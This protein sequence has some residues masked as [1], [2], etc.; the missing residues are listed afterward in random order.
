[1]RSLAIVVLLLGLVG[2][3]HAEPNES[4]SSESYFV[5]NDDNLVI[6]FKDVKMYPV[7]YIPEGYTIENADFI[8]QEW[9]F[10]LQ[11]WMRVN[12]GECTQWMNENGFAFVNAHGVCFGACEERGVQPKEE[13]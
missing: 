3:G 12:L 10:F 9:V 5:E 1:M 2:I 8:G 11:E 4:A 13:K 7:F 6:Q